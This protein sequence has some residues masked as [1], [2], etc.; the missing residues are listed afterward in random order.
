MRA[1]TLLAL[2]LLSANGATSGY[3][4]TESAPTALKANES[5]LAH[6]YY[7][8]ELAFASN[9]ETATHAAIDLPLPRYGRWVGIT[10]WITLA[11][12]IG[13]GAL[14]FSLSNSADDAFNTLQA[15]CNADPPNCRAVNPDGSYQDPRLESLYQDVLSKD[16][17]ARV[18]LI[19]AQVSFGASVLLFIVDFQKRGGPSDI[20]YEPPDE[21]SAL[22][23]TAAPGELALRYYFR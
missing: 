8:A 12:S 22:R 5:L 19:G 14:G 11:S 18:S 6:R 21:Q 9:P 3:A 15:L 10:K 7:L 13:L 17:Q 16:R 20:P 1:L 4:Q 2:L 23:L